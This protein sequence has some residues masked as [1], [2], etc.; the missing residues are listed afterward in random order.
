MQNEIKVKFCNSPSMESINN[1]SQAFKTT[2]ML[3][4]KCNSYQELK[5]QDLKNFTSKS[6][7]I[8]F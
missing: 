2:N 4:E 7:V 5:L 8:F 3:C 1:K 6:E